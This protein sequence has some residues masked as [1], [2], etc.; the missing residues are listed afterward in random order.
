MK[1]KQL[2]SLM[3]TFLVLAMLAGVFT[4]LTVRQVRQLQRDHELIA[5]INTGDEATVRSL[6][7]QGADPNTLDTVRPMTGIWQSLRSLWKRPPQGR[8][9]LELAV[10]SS[11][12]IQTSQYRGIDVDLIE[13]RF[14]TRLPIVQA[15]LD[16]GADIN[17]RSLYRDSAVPTSAT[18]VNLTLQSDTPLSAAILQSRYNSAMQTE[19]LMRLLLDHKADVNQ[20]DAD[21]RTSLTYAI[22]VH[23]VQA[24]RSQVIKLL[25]DRGADVNH[26]DRDGATALNWTLIFNSDPELVQLLRAHGAKADVHSRYGRWALAKA[27]RSETAPLVQELLNAGADANAPDNY[28]DTPL[29]EALRTYHVAATPPDINAPPVTEAAMRASPQAA[30]I[31]LL[32]AKGAD[33]QAPGIKVDDRLLLQKLRVQ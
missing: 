6:L 33:P 29:R 10:N 7:K 25:L 12:G 4:W 18:G 5:A 11:L 8:T 26:A 32:L 14:A 1:R 28:G 27:V 19:Q 24:D 13:A 23:W 16:R 20:A 15:L 2:N 21:G 9:A 30:M 3:L 17:L 22:L 31:R